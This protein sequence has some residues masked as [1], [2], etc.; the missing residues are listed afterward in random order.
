MIETSDVDCDT[1]ASR[2]ERP[3]RHD[4]SLEAFRRLLPSTTR[5]NLLV[6]ESPNFDGDVTTKVTYQIANKARFVFVYSQKLQ[7]IRISAPPG[8]R[9][10]CKQFSTNWRIFLLFEN[11]TKEDTVESN[12]SKLW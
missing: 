2:I 8:R 7:I 5:H 12:E 10:S 1:S 9:R 11:H 4:H 3:T 6:S